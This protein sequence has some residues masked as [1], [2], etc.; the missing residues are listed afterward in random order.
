MK[1]ALKQ[2]AYPNFSFSDSFD[3]IR[4]EYTGKQVH[5]K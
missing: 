5:L 4:N 3:Q 1:T 2:T